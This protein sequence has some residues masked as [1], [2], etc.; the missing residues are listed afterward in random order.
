M[1]LRS[2]HPFSPWNLLHHHGRNLTNLVLRRYI[3]Q[4]VTTSFQTVETIIKVKW[5]LL[6]QRLLNHTILSRYGTHQPP[7]P[8]TF[9]RSPAVPLGWMFGHLLHGVETKLSLSQFVCIS[10]ATYPLS[11]GGDR[12]N[13]GNDRRNSGHWQVSG[14]SNVVD[15]FS[16]PSSDHWLHGRLHVEP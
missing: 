3:M 14:P 8:V 16:P 5:R 6:S 7:L 13:S 10:P 1:I 12:R 4:L 15:N 9:G 2:K 11:G